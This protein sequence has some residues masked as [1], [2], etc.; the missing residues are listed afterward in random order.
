M[1]NE[2]VS[3]TGYIDPNGS[4]VDESKAYDGNLGKGFSATSIVPAK[5]WSNYLELTIGAIWCSGI[6]FYASYW[7]TNGINT[8]DLDV[9][10]SG[11]WI[12]VYYGSFLNHVWVEKTNQLDPMQYVTK[13]RIRFYNNFSDSITAELVEAMFYQVVGIPI[14]ITKAATVVGDGKATLNGNIT[15]TGGANCTTRGFG[16]CEEGGAVQD[17]SESGSFSAGVYSLNL[18]DLDPNKKYYFY[19][20]AINSAGT[21]T[22]DWLSFV[23]EGIDIPTV[24]TS[25]ATLVDYEEATLNGEITTTGGQDPTERGFEWKIGETGT[26][27]T[28]PETGTF[29]IGV[30]SLILEDLENFTEYYFRAYAKNDGGTAYGSWLNFTTDLT[31]PEVVTHNATDELTTSAVLNGEIVKTGGQDC[32][33]EGFEYGL[34]KKAEFTIKNDVGGYGVGYFNKTAIDLTP[35]TEYWY[36]AYAKFESGGGIPA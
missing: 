19:A 4:W 34:T 31:D 30:Y 21:A 20:Y 36:R 22:G 6:K 28:L 17:I 3:P 9:Y 26:I 25:E 11:S 13:M 24:T 33:E 35:N 15:N 29:G 12:S 7:G 23:E 5:S 1:A 8:I 27:E 32:D 2:W 10:Y 16:Y 14:L 18:T